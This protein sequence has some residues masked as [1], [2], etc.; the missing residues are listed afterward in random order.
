MV[1]NVIKLRCTCA[2]LTRLKITAEVGLARLAALHDVYTSNLGHKICLC[3]KYVRFLL[4]A[5][6]VEAYSDPV[7]TS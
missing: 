3:Q 4:K 6:K 7:Q 5:C 2:L 1:L